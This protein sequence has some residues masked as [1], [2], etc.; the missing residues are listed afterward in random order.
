MRPSEAGKPSQLAL[1]RTSPKFHSAIVMG[2][3]T[4]F[5]ADDA[6]FEG[7]YQVDQIGRQSL[8]HICVCAHTHA[9][10]CTA[11]VYAIVCACVVV[12]LFGSMESFLSCAMR[13]G[14]SF[15]LIEAKVP[16]ILLTLQPW[17][18]DLANLAAA[19]GNYEQLSVHR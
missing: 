4:T 16:G 11:H 18:D 3:V 13:L 5:S 15:L 1:Q 8:Q 19:A 10:V 14:C 12:Y 6:K 7:Q 17:H 9:N 2:L